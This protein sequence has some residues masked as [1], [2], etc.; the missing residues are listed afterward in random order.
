MYV[1]DDDK[2]KDIIVVSE[3]LREGSQNDQV[4]IK[5]STAKEKENNSKHKNEEK[6][7]KEDQSKGEEHF[8][9]KQDAVLPDLTK[10]QAW[11]DGKVF[12]RG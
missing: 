4:L 7:E 2:G 8:N 5:S 1:T 3:V 11:L 6:D 10:K 12:N 9:D